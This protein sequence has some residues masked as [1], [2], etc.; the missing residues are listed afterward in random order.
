MAA[1]DKSEVVMVYKR[2]RV[3]DAAGYLETVDLW[4]AEYEKNGLWGVV[5]FHFQQDPE[6]PNLV[7]EVQT[8]VS[9]KAFLDHTAVIPMDLMMLFVSYVQSIELYC[10]GACTGSFNTNPIFC[11]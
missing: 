2:S 11:Y 3:S 9:L 10:F 5:N 7:H 1:P 4:A 6:D 8:F